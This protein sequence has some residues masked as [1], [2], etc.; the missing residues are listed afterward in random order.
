MYL[1]SGATGKQGSATVRNLKGVP[2]RALVRNTH[3][4]AAKK[5]S[6]DGVELASGDLTNSESIYAAMEG[7]DG[8]FLVTTMIPNGPEDEIVQGERMHFSV[9]HT[10]I[11]QVKPLLRPRKGVI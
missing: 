5:L 4:E 11:L 8:A 1:V 3:S 7:V 2:T 10:K 9:K 6:A